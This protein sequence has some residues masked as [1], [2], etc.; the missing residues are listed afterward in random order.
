MRVSAAAG[1][2]LEALLA[3]VEAELPGQALVQME[4]RVAAGDGAALHL[5]HENARILRKRLV[6]DHFEFDVEMTDAAAKELARYR[7]LRCDT[8]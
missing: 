8:V 5:V 1:E 3:R 6:E 4:L 7:H 2:G